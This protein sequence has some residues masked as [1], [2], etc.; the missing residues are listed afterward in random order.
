MKTSELLRAVVNDKA[1]LKK[2]KKSIDEYATNLKS[3][4]QLKKDC[5]EIEAYVKETYGL[6]PTIFKKIVKAS[7]VV[8]DVTDDV[9]EEM[10]LIREIAKSN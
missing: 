8:N 5:K 10:E 7:M 6:P 4:D 9:V 2:V 1:V 3:T